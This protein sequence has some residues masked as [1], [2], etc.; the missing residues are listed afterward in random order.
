M[1]IV[2]TG[3]TGLLG[4]NLLYE[5]MRQNFSEAH[6]TQVFLLGRGSSGNV[7]LTERIRAQIADDAVDYLSSCRSM[8]DPHEFLESSIHCIDADLDADRLNLSPADF[9]T[10]SREPIDIFFHV[11]ALTDFRDTPPVIAAL[12]RTNIEGT[13]CVLELVRALH[14]RQFCYVG[15]AYSCGSQSGHIEPDYI[16]TAERFRNPYERTK[17][18]AELLV[19]SANDLG[20]V[21]RRIFRA[22][23]LCGRLLEQTPGAI[24]KFDVF[25]SWAA[26][27]LRLKVKT[28]GKWEGRYVDNS[29]LDLR[30]CYS[31]ESGL[32]IVPADYAAKIL[33]QV[34][35]QDDPAD[36]FH[37]ANDNETPHS[38]YIEE[39]LRTVNI[40][41]VQQVSDIPSNM[42]ELEKLYYR[43]VGAIFT[44]YITAKP[45]LFDV[46]N[47][48]N[49]A[50]AAGLS[51]PPVDQEHFGVLMRYARYRDFGMNPARILGLPP[52][53]TQPR[54]ATINSAASILTD[55]NFRP[56]RNSPS[57]MRE[58]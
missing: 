14:V 52:S 53:L 27:F 2:I 44:P 12:E 48:A 15:S 57:R 29:E 4:R 31:L 13:R 32:N 16:H 9:A 55:V 37:L 1:R 35:A 46:S 39:M 21:K 36:S 26:W 58:Q 25:Y 20:H 34:C 56:M 43:S 28:T 11:A 41:G 8:E 22:S 6:K 24:S 5:V 45:M 50:K 18:E 47:L 7:S 49:V 40:S 51:C 19:R 54:T 33:Y 3:A 30:A 23:T 38:T 42:N 17:L 10:L